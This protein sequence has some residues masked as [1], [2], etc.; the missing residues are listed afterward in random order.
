VLAEEVVTE[1]RL[2]FWHWIGGW[3]WWSPLLLVTIKMVGMAEK[4]RLSLQERKLL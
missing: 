3:K 1:E 2:L 4:K